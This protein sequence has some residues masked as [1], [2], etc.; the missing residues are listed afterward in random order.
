MRHTLAITA[1]FVTIALAGC[2]NEIGD[3]C[4]LSIDCSSQGDRFCDIS[5]PGGYCT[6]IGCD[7]NNC[8]DDSV[9]IRFFSL[10]QTNITCTWTTEDNGEEDSTND[11][12][13]DE[14]CALS[15]NCMPR[16]AEARFCMR[17]CEDAGDCRAQY[18]CR[19]EE[20]MRLNGGEPVSK[21]GKAPSS[22]LGAFCAPERLVIE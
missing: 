13:A 17:T 6:V 21:P 22:N 20:L 9:C 5:S 19:D 1:A 18:E 3:S 11:C 14:L 15:G 12:T 16:S 2:G 10:A 4:S 8:P 7:Y